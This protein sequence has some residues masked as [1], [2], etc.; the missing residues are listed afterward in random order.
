VKTM[1]VL[2]M[3]K[4]R[5]PQKV[6]ILLLLILLF[7]SLPAFADSSLYEKAR[8]EGLVLVYSSSTVSEFSKLKGLFEKQYSGVKV[9]QLR[10]AGAKLMERILTGF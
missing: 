4:Y 9:E 10:L 7:V 1:D 5:Y 3:L 6:F 8:Q 2:M